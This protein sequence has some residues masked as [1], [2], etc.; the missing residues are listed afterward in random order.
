MSTQFPTKY[1]RELNTSKSTITLPCDGCHKE[2]T[3][4]N[5]VYNQRVRGNKSGKIF[6]SGRCSALNQPI[7]SRERSNLHLIKV[8]KQQKGMSRPECGRKGH[9]VSQET[10]DKIR[11]AKLGKPSPQDTDIILRELQ[12]QRYQKAV[13]TIG[14]V[15]DA[16]FLRDG[17]LIAFELEKKRWETAIRRK[18]EKYDGDTR[19]D[20]VIIVWYNLQGERVKEYRKIDGEWTVYTGDRD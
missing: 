14:L 9:S 7:E 16:I 1:Y 3:L 5:W 15:P 19:Y 4:L 11:N 13:T 12:N 10:R 20:E 18:M 17:K 6:C 8:A 2:I